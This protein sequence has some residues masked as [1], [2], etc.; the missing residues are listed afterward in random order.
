M[1]YQDT[2]A[3]RLENQW[4]GAPSLSDPKVCVREEIDV[5][6]QI[7]RLVELVRTAAGDPK[8]GTK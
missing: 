1:T 4:Y 5:E 6:I 8:K 3:D 2:A 7:R